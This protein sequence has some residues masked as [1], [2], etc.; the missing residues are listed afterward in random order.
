MQLPKVDLDQYWEI[1]RAA[2][3]Y[4]YAKP[5]VRYRAITLQQLWCI[6]QKTVETWCRGSL[7]DKNDAKLQNPEMHM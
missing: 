3:K 2:K 7:L 5:I 6:K 1:W 4:A